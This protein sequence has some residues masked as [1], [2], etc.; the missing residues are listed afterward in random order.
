M[1]KPIYAEVTAYKDYILVEY[2]SNKSNEVL[3]TPFDTE[4]M[5]YVVGDVGHI[6]I[7]KEAYELL[8]SVKKSGDSIGDID[9]FRLANG[10]YAFSTLSGMCF[11]GNYKELQGSS[12]FS[13]PPIESFQLIE[14]NVPPEAIEAINIAL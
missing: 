9:V 8:R 2:K 3:T 5:G 13:V 6:G 10:N 1:T 12:S 7:S 14:N 11:M 4:S